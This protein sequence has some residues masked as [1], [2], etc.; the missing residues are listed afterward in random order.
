[1]HR[2][3]ERSTTAMAIDR[4]VTVYCSTQPSLAMLMLLPSPTNRRDLQT[5]CGEAIGQ[6]DAGTGED[7]PRPPPRP[8]RANCIRQT[9]ICE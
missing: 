2:E 1:M 3:E 9:C 4:A 7:D 5:K 8:L 6:W